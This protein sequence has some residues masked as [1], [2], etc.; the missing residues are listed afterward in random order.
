[1]WP[2]LLACLALLAVVEADVGNVTRGFKLQLWPCAAGEKQSWLIQ[3]DPYPNH[4]ITLRQEQHFVVDISQFSNASDAIVQLWQRN[5][6]HSAYNQQFRYDVES[7][8]IVSLMNGF[9]LTV[10]GPDFARLSVDIDGEMLQGKSRSADVVL[11][12]G[13]RHYRSK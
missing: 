11:S 7:K 3:T 8:Q 4:T 1:M 5:A 13:H 6:F 9:C 12:R 10:F 2:K